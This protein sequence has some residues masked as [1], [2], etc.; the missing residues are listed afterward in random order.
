MTGDE[1]GCGSRGSRGGRTESAAKGPG[2]SDGFCSLPGG[3]IGASGLKNQRGVG[4]L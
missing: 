4:D 1:W 2:R 3:Q